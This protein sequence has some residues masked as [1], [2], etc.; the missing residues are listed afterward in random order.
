MQNNVLDYLYNDNYKFCVNDNNQKLNKKNI[1]KKVAVLEKKIKLK[2]LNIKN[3][4]IVIFLPK[5]AISLIC[6]FSVVQSGNFYVPLDTK[7]PIK[8]ILLILQK[9]KPVLI[10]TN[11]QELKKIIKLKEKF[12]LLS[13]DS[14]NFSKKVNFKKKILLNN[15]DQDP[16]YGIP[17]S[18][19]T[20]EPKIVLVSHRNII[21]YIDWVLKCYKLNHQSIFGNQSPFFFDNSVLDIY[22]SLAA[23]ATLEIIPENKFLFQ[24]ELVSYL[25]KKKINF[26]FWVP[27]ALINIINS[28]LLNSNNTKFLKKILFAGE[29][30]P[31]KYI[32]YLIKKFPNKIYSN[33]YGPTEITVD[34]TYFFINKKISP[35]KTIP[36][37]KPCKNTKII[38]LNKNNKICKIGQKGEILVGGTSVSLGYYNDPEKTKK[39]F[40]QNPLHND[41]RDIVYKTGDLAYLDKNNNYI[42]CGRIDNQIKINGY[43]IELGEIENYFLKISN[44]HRC[45]ALFDDT[46]KKII[47]FYSGKFIEKKNIYKKLSK[48]IP[49][50]AIPHDIIFLK[51]IPLTSNQKI[52]KV[53]LSGDIK[54]YI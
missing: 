21:D 50:Y 35:K 45:V 19:S 42:F 31:V 16:V 41:Y 11:N 44:S 9:I 1:I 20:G 6:F 18:G 23:D 15:L 33:L 37:G 5:S 13:I 52:D 32:N 48:F 27:T 38:L 2:T 53:T 24:A 51:R 12:K 39:S 47:L 10:L 4:P 8:K 3:K 22:A 36:I 49:K 46:S 28:N 29:V 14:I 7:M 34:C 30:L 17:T 54:K 43:R 40:I 25:Y 26:I